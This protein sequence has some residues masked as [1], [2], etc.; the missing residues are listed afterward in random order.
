M[1]SWCLPCEKADETLTI[2]SRTSF[3]G[4]TPRS[5]SD[6]SRTFSKGSATQSL[7]PLVLPWK[8]VLL[9]RKANVEISQVKALQFS[10]D[11]QLFTLLSEPPNSNEC[12]F[13]AWSTE[14]G[15]YQNSIIL[16][17]SV[18]FLRQSFFWKTI[19][20]TLHRVTSTQAKYGSQHS[21]R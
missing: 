1:L 2:S 12:T 5:Q 21:H 10:A 11:S 14:R 19:P 9:N 13:H 15:K 16:E 6:A 4:S 18:C 17:R 3:S 8:H 7:E 20:L